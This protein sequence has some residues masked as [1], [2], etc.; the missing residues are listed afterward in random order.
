MTTAETLQSK[1]AP[2]LLGRVALAL[3]DWRYLTKRNVLRLTRNPEKL[4]FNILQTLMFVLLFRYV[5]GGAIA[6]PNGSYVDFLMPGII[7]QSA[8][9]ISISTAVGLADDINKGIIDRFRAMPI[10][11]SAFMAARLISDS[12]ENAILLSLTI[13]TGVIVGWSLG[14]GVVSIIGMIALALLIGLSVGSVGAW[15]ALT[16]KKPEMVQ[17]F[18]LLWIFPLTFVSGI[19]VPNDTLPSLLKSFAEINPITIW[20]RTLRSLSLAGESASISDVVLTLVTIA[21]VVLIF[22][23]LTVRSYRKMG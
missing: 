2:M 20:A 22:G 17:S 18:G 21:A 1:P 19:F 5:F 8:T 11:R 12:I 7:V 9:F 15:T 10:G 3:S 14:G 6:T 4:L 16:L 23:A 13:I